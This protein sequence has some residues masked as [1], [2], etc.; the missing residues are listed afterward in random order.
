LIPI[1]SSERC[2]QRPEQVDLEDAVDA[3]EHAG[4]PLQPHAGVDRRPRQVDALAAGQLL[5]LHEDEVP[6][7]EEPVAILVRTAGRTAGDRLALVD[8]DLRARPARA[9]VAHLPEV[10]AGRDA[11]DPLIRQPGDLLPQIEGVI[12]LMK[13]GDPKLLLRQAEFL[14]RQPPGELDR[15]FLEVIAEREVAEHLEEREMARGVADIIEIVVLAAGT[16][17]LLRGDGARERRRGAAGEIVLELDHA[18]VGEHQRRVVPR[19]KRTGR[20]ERMALLLEIAEKMRPD[21]VD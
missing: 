13:D 7:L 8:E 14:R 17:A 6:E 1:A 16:H 21:V 5:V 19:H 10:V 2:D 18:G 11:D 20:H 15:M 9:G 4:D 3:L 12:V